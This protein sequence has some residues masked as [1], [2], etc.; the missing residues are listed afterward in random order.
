MTSTDEIDNKSLRSHFDFLLADD[1][2]QIFEGK[3]LTFIISTV[4]H[5]D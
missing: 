5:N 1:T 3:N 4:T 2:S